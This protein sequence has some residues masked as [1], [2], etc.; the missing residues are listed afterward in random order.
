WPREEDFHPNGFGPAV[1]M[2]SGDFVLY[3]RI[4][5]PRN[6]TW[7]YN[8]SGHPN[9][10]LTI[11]ND[12]SV[13]LYDPEGGRYIQIIAPFEFPSAEGDTMY[14]GQELSTLTS[15]NGLIQL[16]HQGDG[17]VVLRAEGKCLWDSH[18]DGLGTGPATIQPDGLFTIFNSDFTWNR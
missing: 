3:D 1:L 4:P 9:A 15:A 16:V 18:T 7:S 8:I 14:V 5:V 2:N 10:H 17:N 13:G 6:M 11:E 12:G